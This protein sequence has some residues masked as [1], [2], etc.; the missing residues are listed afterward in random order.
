MLKHLLST[1]RTTCRLPYDRRVEDRA[2]RASFIATCN[3][4][5]I[6][7]DYTGNRRYWVLD[8]KYGGFKE[9][10]ANRFASIPEKT[11]PGMFCRGNFKDERLQI[12]AQAR[13]LARQGGVEPSEKTLEAMSKLI[14]RMTPPDPL[15]EAER[16]WHELARSTAALINKSKEGWLTNEEIEDRQIFQDISAQTGLPIFKIRTALFARGLSVRR[17]RWRGYRFHR[18]PESEVSSI[19]LTWLDEAAELQT[20]SDEIEDNGSRLKAE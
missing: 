16:L 19:G 9:V 3:V 7:R 10:N 6:L 12:I 18:M 8:I 11:Y 13:H 15:K 14:A 4:E 20:Q 1:A 17:N 2:V 5:D